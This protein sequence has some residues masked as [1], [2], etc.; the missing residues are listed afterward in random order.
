MDLKKRYN[1]LIMIRDY[2]RLFSSNYFC[3]LK[4]EVDLYFA[5]K[6][7]K[8]NQYIVIINEIE[9]SIRKSYYQMRPVHLFDRYISDINNRLQNNE[10]SNLILFQ[11]DLIKYKI[12]QIIL[13]NSSMLFF[14][15]EDAFLLVI[16]D[17]YIKRSKQNPVD[18][19]DKVFEHNF[20]TEND[21]HLYQMYEKLRYLEKKPIINLN[22][23]FEKNIEICFDEEYHK[24][25]HDYKV[26]FENYDEEID[27]HDICYL[28]PNTFKAYTNLAV[29]KFSQSRIIH[30]DSCIFQKLINL[31]QIDFSCNHIKYIHP[32]AFNGLKSLL[33]IDFHSN[34]LTELDPKLFE[35]LVSL[36]KI[37][38]S[39][40]LINKLD[41]NIFYG[42]KKVRQINFAL[43]NLNYL[44]KN[45]FNG[46]E[47]IQ[48][49]DFTLNKIQNYNEIF[50][51]K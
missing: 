6:N 24:N 30:L 47:N 33:T 15:D 7:E 32:E 34:N 11:I 43:N 28:N 38:F 19:D 3:N 41:V 39:R 49:I 50:K 12:E 26:L 4:C 10:H 36:E 22:L 46:L 48:E 45:T 29:L 18:D 23:L 40:N 20:F 17:V 42:L 8:K 14:A 44:D 9:K 21:L 25:F 35:G 16:N 13:S 2:P 5:L 31:Q 1:E 37:N 51:I 27:R